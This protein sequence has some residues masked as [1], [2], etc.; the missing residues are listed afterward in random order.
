MKF[1][2]QNR[3]APAIF[4]VLAFGLSAVYFIPYLVPVHEKLSDSYIFGYNNRAAVLILLAFTV[5]FALWTRGLGLRLPVASAKD[6]DPFRRTAAIA[7]ALS[8][9]GCAVVWALGWAIGPLWEAL[10]FLDRYAMFRMGERLY[11]D[12]SFYYGPLMFYS[13]VWIAKV[14]GLSL[15]NGYF[16]AWLLQWALGVWA[17][18]K[19]VEVAARGTRH[20]RAI[21]LLLWIMIIPA[22][23]DSGLNYTPFRFCGTLA[24][25]IGVHSLY[26]RG[27]SFLAT[28]GFACLGATVM[29]LYSPEQG[30]ALTLATV[31][32]FGLYVRP[33]RRGLPVALACFALFMAITFGL[34][35]RMG[36]L[37][38]FL[39]VGGG[40]LNFPLLFSFQSLLLLLLLLAAGCA[41]VESIRTHTSQSVLLYLICV[42]V[43]LAPAAFSR[44]DVGH[45]LLNMLGALIAALV[46]L[47]QY[48]A[49]WRWTWPS[50][51]L[52]IILTTYG[53]VT[54]VKSAV[55]SQVHDAVFGA[56]NPSPGFTKVYTAI[57]KLTHRHAQSR[58]D[59]LRASFARDPEWSAPH[60][61]ANTHLLAP[62][63][64]QRRITPPPDGIQI[65][66]GRYYAFFPVPLGIPER[67]AEMEAHPDWPLLVPSQAPVSC[68]F[69]PDGERT[70]LRKFLLAPYIPRPRHVVDAGRPLCDYLNAHYTPG[71]YA[72]PTLGSVVWVRKGIGSVAS[73]PPG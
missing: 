18:W 64:V 67:I 14:C 6:S 47:S 41:A 27:A 37:G 69:D 16:L 25:A 1:P 8:A 58:L 68:V 59:Q 38:D 63:G 34:A 31:L 4:V 46:I 33:A 48:P 71:P 32:F 53:K 28:F 10:Y 36:I 7:I 9:F 43:A 55:Q 30:I 65:V 17:L 12:L 13:S 49:A 57:Y 61:P 23:F 52:L 66:S 11:K 50:F 22:I 39:Q 44:A 24:C 35:L 21:F 73:V 45:I 51:V 15:G 40:V 60:L 3:S 56:R 26:T 29:L 2:T 62:M 5:G 72:S 19:V 42:S 70:M 20:G 54:L